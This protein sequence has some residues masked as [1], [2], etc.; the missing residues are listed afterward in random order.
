MVL[1]KELLQIDQLSEITVVSGDEM[2]LEYFIDILTKE[3]ATAIKHRQALAVVILEHGC[4]DTF[5]LWLGHSA[6]YVGIDLD[7]LSINPNLS[8]AHS[9]SKRIY[10]MSA[11]QRYVFGATRL[12]LQGVNE[13]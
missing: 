6:E 8:A 9:W 3:N 7:E 4:S 2:V 10:R 13:R 12:Q 11:A 5:F 1:S